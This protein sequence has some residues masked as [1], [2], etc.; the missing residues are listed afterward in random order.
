MGFLLKF[1][2]CISADKKQPEYDSGDR[3]N[4]SRENRQS[5]QSTESPSAYP[6]KGP[7][8]NGSGRRAG[9]VPSV[10]V[11]SRLHDPDLSVAGLSAVESRQPLDR[12]PVNDP[13]VGVFRL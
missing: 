13:I 8:R 1:Q 6:T 5:T 3:T 4:N 2:S 7:E 10:Y 11:E 9:H 12:L